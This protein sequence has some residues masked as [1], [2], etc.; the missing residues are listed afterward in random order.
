MQQLHRGFAVLQGIVLLLVLVMAGCSGGSGGSGGGT[1]PPP[2]TGPTPGST[3]VRIEGRAD[4]GTL[5]SPIAHATCRFL[6]RNGMLLAQTTAD[7]NGAFHLDVAPNVQG[8]IQ[9]N[10]PNQRR[11]QLATF[12][13]T[14]G[15]TAGDTIPPVGR[16]QVTPLTTIMAELIKRENPANPQARREAILTAITAQDPSLTAIVESATVLY[17]PLLEAQLDVDFGGTISAEG[18]TDGGEGGDGGTNGDEDGGADEGGTEGTNDDGAE[19]SPIASAVCDFSRALDSPTMT[20]TVLGDLLEDG[21]VDRPDLQ[22]IAD[23]VNQALAGRETAIARAFA[24]LFPTGIGRPLRDIADG[25]GTATPGRYFLPVPSGVSGFVR[26]RPPNQQNLLLATFVRAREP[27]ETLRRQDVTPQTTVFSTN[28]A[29]TLTDNLSTTKENFLHDIA[30]LRIRF[31]TTNGRINGF[32]VVDPS[33]VNNGDVGIVT[34]VATAL[35]NT[36]LQNGLDVDFIAA[37]TDLS[38]RAIVDSGSLISLGVPVS[39]ANNVANIVNDSTTTAGNVLG[40]DLETGLSTARIIVQVIDALSGSTLQGATVELI[41][42]ENGVQCEMCLAVTDGNGQFTFTLSEV[43]PTSTTTLMVRATQVGFETK[44]VPV[45]LVGVATVSITI[46]IDPLAANILFASDF[47]TADCLVA[48]D[49]ESSHQEG[50]NI[51]NCVFRNASTRGHLFKSSFGEITLVPAVAPFPF[52]RN[53]TF[54]FEM[55]VKVS[56]EMGAPN[57]LYGTSGVSFIFR[58]S[59]DVLLG[60][61]DYETAT[62]NFP[63]E[64][65]A[66]DQTKAAIPIQPNI[67]HSIFLRIDD[68][69]DQITIDESKIATVEMLFRAFTSTRPFPL[70]TA[71]LWI[72]NIIVADPTFIQISHKAWNE[73]HNGSEQYMNRADSLYARIS[74]P[75]SNA[76]VRGNVPIFGLAYGKDFKEYRVEYGEGREPTEWI[77][78]ASS[79]TPQTKNVTLADLD[80]SS[81]I[82]IYGNLATWDTGLKN[83]VYLPSHPKDHPIDLNGVYTVRLVVVGKDGSTIEDRRTVEVADVIPNAWGGFARSKDEKVFLTVPEQA[84]MDSFRLISIKREDIVPVSLPPKRQLIGSVYEFREPGERFTKPAVLEMQFAKEAIGGIHPGQLG[85]Y[86]YHSEKQAWEYLE[87]SRQAHGNTIS[88]KVRELYSYYALMASGIPGEGSMPEPESSNREHVQVDSAVRTSGYYLSKDTFED[89]M[90]EWSNRDGEV[91]ADVTL[92]NTATFDGT[93]CL[94]ITNTNTG[95]NFAVN[96]RRTPFD[97]REFPIV[98]FDYN[99]LSDVKTNFLVKVS[100]RWYEIGFTDDPKELKHKR[101]NIAHLGTIKGVVADGQWHTAQFNL[102]NMLRT[103]TGNFLVE[104]MIMA[105]WNVGGYMKL[106]FGQNANGAT[107]YIDNFTISREVT[108]GTRVQDD[109]IVVDHFNQKKTTNVFSGSTTLFSGINDYIQMTFNDTGIL[110]RGHALALSY[111]LQ[112]PGGYAGYISELPHLDLREYHALTFDVKGAEG[113]EDFVIGMKDRLGHERKV[114]VSG[115][116]PTKMRTDWQHVTIPLVAFPPELDWG[117]L[118]NLSLAFEQSLHAVG[119]V[120]IDNIAFQKNIN[121]FVLDTFTNA[122][123]RNFLGGAHSTFISGAAAIDGQY[124]YDGATGLYRISYGGS[125]GEVKA[126]A[127][128]PFTYAMWATELGGIDC[129]QCGTLSFLIRGAKGGEKPNIYLDDGNFRWGVAIEKYA[130]VTT[131][132]QRVIIPLQ[133]FADYGVDLTHVAALQLVFEWEKMSGTIYLDD[134]QFGFV[135]HAISQTRVSEDTK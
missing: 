24:A 125:I 56:S 104:E 65:A 87:S 25:E 107:Y 97:V 29:T 85:I 28:I 50:I 64:D 131:A 66:T 18:E 135:S 15:H 86:A 16:E 31:I 105:D 58:D 118:I 124:V 128:D 82:T 53:L 94:K 126:Y 20:N 41:D 132:W 59:N 45:T 78:L 19:F 111:S 52:H 122:Q 83:Y 23:R 92:D 80:S 77:N 35:F 57:N 70:V 2:R 112:Q 106:Q 69:L 93:W 113:G 38:E 109:S 134:I 123:G 74:I 103:K 84:L 48:W 79:T 133:E 68:I 60:N 117:G 114:I 120:F 98:Q 13:S 110:G 47:E 127:S 4:D 116:L 121:A 43:Q 49:I 62:T 36:L 3:T 129:S 11:L 6:D 100:G 76:L 37:L 63:F 89:S 27:G 67:N 101:V 33:G 130:S 54:N 34:F 102:R 5:S 115:Y 14:L 30:G 17:K 51:A 61:V 12:I 91:G 119:V 96:I 75:Y 26:C 55:E 44:I 72:D 7:V 32:E 40:T 42:V 108:A 1:Q 10:P 21:R 73:N 99:I 22:V 88:T 95:G 81:D 8:F 39:Q 9:C 71:E 46:A 90:G